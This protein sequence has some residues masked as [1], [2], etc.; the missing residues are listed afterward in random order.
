MAETDDMPWLKIRYSLPGDGRLFQMQKSLNSDIDTV[1][2]K[3]MRLW[4]WVSQESVNG[5]VE[6]VIPDNID[7]VVGKKGFAKALVEVRWLIFTKAGCQFMH[8]DDHLSGLA[9]RMAVDDYSGQVPG[10][11]RHEREKQKKQEIVSTTNALFHGKPP[12]PPK[13]PSHRNLPYAPGFDSFWQ[14][15]PRKQGKVIALRIWNKINP[16]EELLPVII[17]ALKDQCTW[18]EWLKDNGQYIPHAST[19]LNQER[20]NDLPTKAATKEQVVQRDEERLQ[21]IA[22]ERERIRLEDAQRSSLSLKKQEAKESAA[23]AAVIKEAEED[24]REIVEIPG[25]MEA[26]VDDE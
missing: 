12:A 17:K 22:A 26:Y 15:Y 21:E 16:G 19:W 24:A 2:G 3:L 8:F 1:L 11:I 10:H 7:D 14:Q 20:W 18:P 6:G 23:V 4:I 5:Y 13:K 9:K 25:F